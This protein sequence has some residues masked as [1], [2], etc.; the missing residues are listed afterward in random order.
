[1]AR[2]RHGDGEKDLMIRNGFLTIMLLAG[3]FV[4]GQLSSSRGAMSL[5]NSGNVPAPKPKR[6]TNRPGNTMGEVM[7]L[8]Y[9]RI[10]DKESNMVRSRANF[11]SDLA[12]LYKNGYRPVTLRE[13]ATGKM[14]L[15]AGSSPV[16]LTFDDSWVDQF[17]FTQ[18]GDVDPGCFVGIWLDFA[19]TH[20]DFPV[21]GTFFALD[22][23]PFGVKKEGR[24]KIK[25]LQDWGSEIASH[26]MNHIDLRKSSAE[27][28]KK[29]V[30]D[31]VVWLENL[32]AKVTS[33][34]PPY[35]SYPTTGIIRDGFTWKGKRIS[36]SA[37]VA[38]GAGPGKSPLDKKFKPYIIPRIKAYE[39]ERGITWWLNKAAKG[40]V[41]LYVQP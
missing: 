22:N 14:K 31:S 1:M 15:P 12:K 36:F 5:A 33:L 37:V 29:E 6:V 38:A 13:Y 9:H 30:G 28:I 39:G 11:K 18:K 20:P 8:M 4:P 26:T 7:V 21:K 25:M 2:T 40:K 3:I 23:G 35:G 34:A 41:D 32:G 10:G 16:V 17:R 24:K 27:R 19:K